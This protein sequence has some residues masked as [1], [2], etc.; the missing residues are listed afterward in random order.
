M[1]SDWPVTGHQSV[2]CSVVTALPQGYHSSFPCQTLQATQACAC[3]SVVHTAP[4]TPVNLGH[5]YS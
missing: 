1:I 4:K 5:H 2:L 3:L